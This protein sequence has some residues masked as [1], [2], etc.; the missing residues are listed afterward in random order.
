MATMSTTTIVTVTVTSRT[1]D[2]D[3]ATGSPSGARCDYDRG[4]FG[5][6]PDFRALPRCFFPGGPPG[7]PDGVLASPGFFCF[8]MIQ[9]CYV[10]L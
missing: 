3:G 1:S 9:D 7:L 6:L 4:Y 10:R 5:F 8:P 2:A